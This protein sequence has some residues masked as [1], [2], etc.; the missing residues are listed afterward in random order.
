MRT[1][2]RARAGGKAEV[3]AWPFVVVGREWRREGVVA[4]AGGHAGVRG[5][6]RMYAGAGPGLWSLITRVGGKG[7][8]RHGVAERRRVVDGEVGLPMS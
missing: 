1:A 4:G 7:W 8:R 6:G 2:L 5:S 3:V